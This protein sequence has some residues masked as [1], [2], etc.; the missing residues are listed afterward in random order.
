VVGPPERTVALRLLEGRPWVELTDP[1]L[2]VFKVLPQYVPNTHPYLL[3]AV[4]TFGSSYEVCESAGIVGVYSFTMGSERGEKAGRSRAP[5][6]NTR[7]RLCRG[8]RCDVTTG[9]PSTA[10]EADA[11]EAPRL[12]EAFASPSPALVRGSGREAVGGG[13]GRRGPVRQ[14]RA[15]LPHR[16]FGAPP[17]EGEVKHLTSPSGGGGGEAD[18]G[19]RGRAHPPVT[20]RRL[21]ERG[22]SA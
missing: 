2:P 13:A 19:G 8:R 16:P 20:P 9:S 4:G 10:R 22:R 11:A 15:R 1:E 12:I 7:Q 6:L 14:E 3:R 21:G 5:R 17:P 18:G